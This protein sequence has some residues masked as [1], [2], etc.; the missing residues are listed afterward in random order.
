MLQTPP[1]IYAIDFGTS[2]SLLAAANAQRTYPPIPL[3]ELGLDPS[4][5][6]SVFL[7][8]TRH[9]WSFG[10]EAIDLYTEQ[11]GEARLFRSVKKFLPD[12]GFTGT[13]IHGAFYSIID[14]VA[15]FLKHMRDKANTYYAS[16]VDRVVLG[17][18]A[19]FSMHAEFDQLAE[20]RLASAARIAGF[21]HVSFCAEPVA[22]AYDFK[23]QVQN[24]ALVLI[25]DFGGGTSDFSILRMGPRAIRREDVLGLGGISLAGDAYDGSIMKHKISAHFGTTVQYKMPMGRNVLAF[26]AFLLSKLNSPADISFLARKDTAQLLKNMQAWCVTGE[27]HRKLTQLIALAEEGLGFAIYKPIEQVKKELSTCTQ[28]LFRFHHPA[29]IAIEESIQQTEFVNFS[30]TLTDKILATLKEIMQQAQVRAADIDLVCLTGGT[31]QMKSIRQAFEDLFDK[32]KIEQF[33][34]FHSIINGL[35]EH[36]KELILED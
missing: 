11:T 27:D 14:L 13:Q 26:P 1:S 29:G 15:V 12:P 21:K 7:S 5:L 28:S 17:R 36:A 3:D 24:E 4:I 31:A 35:A 32:R 18:P 30:Q 19:A 2:N 34:F 16:D 33:H 23:Q 9:H 25:A 8:P 6:R 22:A 20:K 10:Q